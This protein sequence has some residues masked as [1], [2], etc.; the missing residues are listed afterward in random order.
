MN[1]IGKIF[2]VLIFVMSIFFMTMAIMV[3]ATHKNWRTVVTDPQTGLQK[4]LKDANAEKADLTTNKEKLQ[5]ELDDLKAAKQKE[6]A[7]LENEISL[8][9]NEA[10][11]Y[12]GRGLKPGNMQTLVQSM[13]IE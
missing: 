7:A 8:K 1:L 13:N 4:Q 6:L 11:V 2:T 5:K 12:K 9:K 10:T 3:Y